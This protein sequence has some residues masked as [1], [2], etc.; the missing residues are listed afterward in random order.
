MELATENHAFNTPEEAELE[1][2]RAFETMDISAM[3]SVWHDQEY[4]ECIHPMGARLKGFLPIR[5]S[6]WEI[7]QQAPLIN[8]QILD[9]KIIQGTNLA[10]H[11]VNEKIII[12]DQME[13]PNQMIATNIFELTSKGWRMILHHASPNPQEEIE[14]EHFTIPQEHLH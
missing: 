3:M 9:Q 8:F 4:I 10:V 12:R 1:F 2:Y 13:Q 6:W 14:D 5:N 11:I 7:F